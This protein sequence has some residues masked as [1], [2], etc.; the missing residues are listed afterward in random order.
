MKL[1]EY[2]KYHWYAF[3]IIIFIIGAAFFIVSENKKDDKY[4]NCKC[5]EVMY[6]KKEY[7]LHLKDGYVTFKCSFCNKET[8]HNVEKKRVYQKPT[9]TVEGYEKFTYTCEDVSWFVYEDIINLGFE[10]HKFYVHNPGVKP[11]CLDGGISDFEICSVCNS[12][13]GGEELEPLGHSLVTINKI[14]PTC[15]EMG[16]TEV[17][18]CDK[19]DYIEDYGSDIEP[20]GHDYVT[21]TVEPTYNTDGYTEYKCTRGDDSYKYDY[22]DCLFGNYC[23][24]GLS[25]N[26][27]HL[28]SLNKD[29]EELIIPETINGYPVTKIN[30]Y[31]S[32]GVFD[33]IENNCLKK[34][35]IPESITYIGEYAFYKCLVLEEINFLTRSTG[36][37]IDIRAFYGCSSLTEIVFPKKCYLSEYAFSYCTNLKEVVIGYDLTT[38]PTAAFYGCNLIE[39]VYYCG[40]QHRWEEKVRISAD[41]NT[42]KNANIYFYSENEPT[43]EGKY[44]HYD[45]DGVTIVIW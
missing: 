20:L 17:I 19:C 31:F 26:V 18:A 11:T 38:I 5:G 27:I 1:L 44:W 7:T 34:L 30:N 14:N 12:T 8:N 45:S 43:A 42:I 9:C 39:N 22:V 6:L 15:T 33:R 24:Y 35:T 23:T 29:V 2:I 4:E 32:C 36:V 10:E 3:G 25:E 40:A 16:H 13:R 41:N 21:E 37:T 28:Y